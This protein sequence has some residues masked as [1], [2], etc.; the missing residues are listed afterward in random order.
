MAMILRW[1]SEGLGLGFRFCVTLALA[2]IVVWI[3][4]GLSASLCYVP[5]IFVAPPLVGG[6]I[7]LYVRASRCEPV[8]VATVFSGFSEGRYWPSMGV[9]WLSA[10][11]NFAASTPTMILF[12]LGLGAGIAAIAKWGAIGMVF[13]VIL[14]P[15]A[16]APVIY[17]QSRLIWS[18]P[19]VLDGRLGVTDAFGAS[20]RLTGQILKGFGMFVML[21]LLFMFAV[22]AAIAVF[23]ISTAVFV[24]GAGVTAGGVAL[25]E[26]KLA[27]E[28]GDLDFGSEP[29]PGE[30]PQQQRERVHRAFQRQQKVAA[31]AL[32][33]VLTAMLIAGGVWIVLSSLL[34]AVVVMPVFVGY[35]D[36]APSLDRGPPGNPPSGYLVGHPL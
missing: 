6:L 28:M 5:W 16:F 18:M 15:L 8:S 2:G 10:L 1:I 34:G 23:S 7:L 26:K 12:F 20:W 36:M 32:S 33:G 30:T 29:R 4:S 9:F 17:L 3:L 11:I 22:A 21:I 24:G 35:R 27:E 13:L 19:L 14:V 25:Q 31:G